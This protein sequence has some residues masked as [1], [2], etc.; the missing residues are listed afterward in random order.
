VRIFEQG[1]RRETNRLPV[2]LNPF[3]I[4]ISAKV[5]LKTRENRD[6]CKEKEKHG[7]MWR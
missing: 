6:I 2:L 7:K 5:F 3:C 1:Q 4:L